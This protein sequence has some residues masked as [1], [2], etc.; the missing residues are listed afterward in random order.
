MQFTDLSTG[1]L[2][3]VRYA[4]A[5]IREGYP[6]RYCAVMGAETAPLVVEAESAYRDGDDTSMSGIVYVRDNLCF[7]VA[8]GSFEDSMG[9]ADKKPAAAEAEATAPKT[10]ALAEE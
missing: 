3:M 1:D 4:E 7:P 8:Q 5:M 10:Q 2:N 6:K 9:A